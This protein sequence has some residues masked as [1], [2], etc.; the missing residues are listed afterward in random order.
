MKNFDLEKAKAGAKVVTRDGRP[1]RFLC[2]DAKGKFPLIGLIYEA[3]ELAEAPANWTEAGK[4]IDASPHKHHLDLFM[5]EL[6]PVEVK[7]WVNIGKDGTILLHLSKE[8]AE[9]GAGARSKKAYSA[10]AVELTGSY[11]PEE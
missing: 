9:G 7:L 3:S 4:Y 5:E 6:K 2:F 8:S 11:I 10:V 1:V